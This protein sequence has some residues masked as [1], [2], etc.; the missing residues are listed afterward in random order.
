MYLQGAPRSRSVRHVV[1][2]TIKAFRL[3]DSNQQS[4]NEHPPGTELICM[5]FRYFRGNCRGSLGNQTLYSLGN[6]I[7]L[8]NAQNTRAILRAGQSIPLFDLFDRKSLTE[9]PLVIRISRLSSFRAYIIL[10]RE[11]RPSFDESAW[12]CY[13]SQANQK[14]APANESMTS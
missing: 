14:R 11:G 10:F 3:S 9:Q 5:V 6:D 13:D 4:A 1:F 7:Y 12:S 8:S 2:Q